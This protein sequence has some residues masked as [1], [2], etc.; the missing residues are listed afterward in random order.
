MYRLTTNKDASDMGMYELAHNCCY[1]KEGLTRYR[2]FE[3]DEDVR[4]LA[5]KLMITYG[6]WKSIEEHGVDGDNELIDD[7]LFDEAM[8]ENLMYKPERIEGLIAVFYRNLWAMADL[9]DSLKAYED[10]EEQGLFLKLPCKV[11]DTAYYVHREYCDR[12][13]KWTDHIDEVIVDSFVMNVNLFVNVSLYIGGD[14]FGKTL[15]PYK[16]LFF[17]REEAEQ[18]LKDMK[19]E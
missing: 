16:T 18:A 17:T 6:I 5:R 13:K 11:D 15:T 1:I 12:T 2:D 10:A 4:E 8:I 9:R 3:T 14:R 19:G 7:E